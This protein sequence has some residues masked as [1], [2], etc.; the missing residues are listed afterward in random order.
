MKNKIIL[1]VDIVIKLALTYVYAN[2]ILHK[3]KFAK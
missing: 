2:N 1:F 3:I